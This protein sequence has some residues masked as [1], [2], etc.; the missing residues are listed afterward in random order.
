MVSDAQKALRK[1]IAKAYYADYLERSK[2]PY[3][4][5]NVDALW[6]AALV[7]A[8]RLLDLLD[9][10]EPVA[11]LVDIEGDHPHATI[12]RSDAERDAE[13]AR[14]HTGKPVRVV[15]LYTTPPPANPEPKP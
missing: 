3:Y 6:A 5:D 1:R 14:G 15:P 9:T 10:Q 13:H 12:E 7:F 11:W 4:P 8:E 2:D